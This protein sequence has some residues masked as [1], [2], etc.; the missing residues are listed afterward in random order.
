[1]SVMLVLIGFLLSY[2]AWRQCNVESSRRMELVLMT[3][4]GNQDR[5][6][7]FPVA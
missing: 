5:L 7:K 2:L 1:M 6:K 3:A 4:I